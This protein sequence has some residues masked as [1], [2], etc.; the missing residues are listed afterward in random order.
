MENELT[1]LEL[2]QKVKKTLNRE[3]Q[4]TYWVIAE[5]SELKINRKG[6]CYLDLVEKDEFGDRI[7]A[8]AK[9]IIWSYTF[10]ML[11]PYFETS[12]GREFKQGLKIMVNVSVEFHELYGYSLYIHDIE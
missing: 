3:F 1:L 5:I 10:R 8:K 6:H 12:T 7:V 11:K 2:N 4:N 9:G